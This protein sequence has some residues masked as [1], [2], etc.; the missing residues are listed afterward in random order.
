MKVSFI[1]FNLESGSNSS[2]DFLD[3]IQELHEEAFYTDF[4]K[5]IQYKWLQDSIYAKIL[6]S[7]HLIFVLLLDYQVIVMKQ[8]DQSLTKINGLSW[9]ILCID[10]TLCLY[11]TA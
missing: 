4:S 1:P 11:E 7:I 5:I 3:R 9:I 8:N 6:A 10:A 2:L